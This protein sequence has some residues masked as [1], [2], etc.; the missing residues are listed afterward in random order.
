MLP[1]HDVRALCAV[2]PVQPLISHSG[3]QGWP[4]WC[5]MARESNGL[6]TVLLVVAG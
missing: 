6:R 1:I 4:S 3:P 5:I 2:M